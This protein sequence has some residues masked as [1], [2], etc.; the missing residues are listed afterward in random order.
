MYLNLD[1]LHVLLSIILTHIP[2]VI[3]KPSVQC[4]LEFVYV[5]IWPNVVSAF[6]L[7]YH[8]SLFPRSGTCRLGATIL[9]PSYTSDIIP[10]L[11]PLLSILTFTSLI[12]LFSHPSYLFFSLLTHDLSLYLA[13]TSIFD[14]NV[15]IRVFKY[16]VGPSEF[17]QLYRANCRQQIDCCCTVLSGRSSPTFVL[18]AS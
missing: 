10:V 17:G 8:H 4:F 14:L 9:S 1:L 5:G 16:W 11:K 2:S 3:F 7:V 18:V 15:P 13:L 12:F 6:C